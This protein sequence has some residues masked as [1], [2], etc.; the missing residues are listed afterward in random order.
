MLA[1]LGAHTGNAEA[2]FSGSILLVQ[3]DGEIAGAEAANLEVPEREPAGEATSSSQ[4]YT[5]SVWNLRNDENGGLLEVE[6]FG[7]RCQRLGSVQH[8][9]QLLSLVHVVNG[10]D[11]DARTFGV[12]DCGVNCATR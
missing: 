4:M 12:R 3:S 1:A 7:C 9:I 2:E 10:K 8:E 11:S 6:A 5:L